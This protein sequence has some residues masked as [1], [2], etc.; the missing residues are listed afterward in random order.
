MNGST[1]DWLQAAKRGLEP[2]FSG[3]DDPETLI[4]EIGRTVRLYDDEP[5]RV[6]WAGTLMSEA[7]AG[8]R[9]KRPP[10][11]ARLEPDGT[12]MILDGKST[13]ANLES[14]GLPAVPLVVA[15]QNA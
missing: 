14:L 13:H 15:G 9:P 10:L 7:A 5:D 1:S 12:Y 2:Y 4:V 8:K 11:S 3:L 6:A